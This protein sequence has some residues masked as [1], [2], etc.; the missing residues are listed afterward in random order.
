M[1]PPIDDYG[2]LR[3]TQTGA[4]VSMAG[5]IDRLCLP[6]LESAAP[7]AALFGGEGNGCWLIA[8]EHVQATRRRYRRDTLVLE[9][10]FDTA[11][12][13]IRLVDFMPP[14]GTSP[15]VVRL[16]VGIRGQV[17]VQMELRPRFD[18]G[19]IRRWVRH[20]D[21]ADVAVAGPDS[22]SLRTPVKTRP[23]DAA[24]RADFL[25]S[26]GELVPFVLAWHP[27]H[28]PTPAPIDPLRALADAECF[29]AER[30]SS[31][32]LAPPPRSVPSA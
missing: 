17:R 1:P 12:G 29:W 9:T 6:R 27:S 21:G 7:F 18:H 32:R 15:H 16:V 11:A 19:R 24:V 13:S 30:I 8:P 31:R 5:S 14:R 26:A 22:V 20:S 2:L 23:E 4:L 28:E 10:D 25:V 3:D